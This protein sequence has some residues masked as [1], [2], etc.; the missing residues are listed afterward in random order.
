M[1]NSD[2]YVTL[3]SGHKMP[4]LGLG[5]FKTDDKEIFTKAITEV[6]Y[7]HIDTAAVYEN[8]DIV[9]QGIADA[10]ASG[11]VSR[12]ELFVTTKL[13]GEDF[14]DPVAACKKSL[15]KLK[16]DYTD[17]YLVHWPI[18]SFKDDG[19]GFERTPMYKVWEGMEKCVDEGL[20]KSIGI[21]NFNVQAICDLLTYCNIKPVCN[22]VEVHP[23]NQQPELVKFCRKFDI[24]CVCY[25][26]I[27]RTKDEKNL[28]EEQTMKDIAKKHGKEPAQ[29][30]LAWNLKRGKK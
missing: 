24:V 3:S 8:E 16:L 9:G 12:E 7:R 17:L 28:L 2:N 25:S 1:E 14:G 6:G 22:Q 13:A 15:E 11:K 19:K 20:A 10:L 5:A 21:S 30:A 26:P 29:V 23:Y 27:A 18:A 4:M